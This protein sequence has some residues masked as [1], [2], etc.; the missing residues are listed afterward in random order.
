MRAGRE[1]KNKWYRGRGRWS[2]RRGKRGGDGEG[3]KEKF[4]HTVKYGRGRE[5]NVCLDEGEWGGS[6]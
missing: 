2:L 3:G 6:L 1:R 5:K 4:A